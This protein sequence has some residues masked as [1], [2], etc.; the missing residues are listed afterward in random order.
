[1]HH[2]L[3][4]TI[5]SLPAETL[6]YCGHEYTIA[7]LKYAR[8]MRN[9]RPIYFCL[10]CF[11]PR[12]LSTL[13]FRAHCFSAS[14][15]VYVPIHVCIY[16]AFLFVYICMYSVYTYIYAIYIYIFVLYFMLIVVGTGSALGCRFAATVEPNNFALQN[17]LE[18]A[19]KQQISGKPTVPSSIGEV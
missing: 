17:K 19:Q 8:E 6:V 11:I 16:S 4:K 7:N 18:W 1:M 3:M 13:L 14:T 10:N 9:V 12:S 2:A 15:M 5:G